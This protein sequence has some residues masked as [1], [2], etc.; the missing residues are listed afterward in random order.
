MPRAFP[1]NTGPRSACHHSSFRVAATCART[2]WPH[3]APRSTLAGVA[4]T[5]DEDRLRALFD[6]TVAL[7]SELSLDVVLQRLVET[8]ASLT[9]ARYGALGVLD[10]RGAGLERFLTTGVDE[11]VHEA[12]GHPPRGRGILGVMIREAAPL[13]LHEIADDPRSVGFPAGHPPMHTFLGVPVLLRGQAYGHL[14]LTEKADG[15]DFTKNDEELVTL[16]AAQAAVAIENARLYESATRWSRQLESLHEI[17]RSLGGETDLES[18]LALLCHRLRDLI[19]ARLAL[20]ALPNAAGD[21]R[22]AAVD[23]EDDMEWLL[24]EVLARHGSKT[25]RVLDRRQSARVDSIIDDPEV[26]QDEARRMEIRTGIYVPLVAA[27][28]AIG[29]VAVHDRLGVEARFS[30]ADL[31]LA[32]IF[33]GHAAVAVDLSERVARDTVGRVLEAQELERRRLAR[34]LHDETGQ[35]LTSILLGL[36]G[37]RAARSDDEAERVEGDLRELVVQALQDV[38]SL[39]V[40]LRPAALDDFG[41]VPALDRLVETFSERSGIEAVVEAHIGETRLPPET[42][43]VLYRLVQEA[44]TN[45]VKH[46]GAE[47]VSI[48]LTRRERRV[49]AVIEDDGRGFAD[50]DVREGAL[51]LVGMRERLALLGGTLAVESRPGAG[52]SLAAYVPVPS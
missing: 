34:E 2:R 5:P 4:V 35:A 46:A 22:I 44:L 26:D 50:R 28:R 32:E 14:Y 51:G 21:L 29:I 16:L 52:T 10:E 24:G 1:A 9:R 6:A 43:T 12:I 31:R 27:G 13:R 36:K 47:H 41:L 17:V 40:E 45:V 49:T 38:R 30:N 18:L 20:I 37:I 8:A 23:A 3:R 7:T 19:G 33:A 11:S 39:A 48:V 25:G 42:E 15:E